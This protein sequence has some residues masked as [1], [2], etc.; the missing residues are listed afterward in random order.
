MR[1]LIES[2]YLP[3]PQ[4]LLKIS[5]AGGGTVFLAFLDFGSVLQSSPLILVCASWLLQ[6]KIMQLFSGILVAV[7]SVTVLVQECNIS[8]A[9]ETC[10]G[11]REQ[12]GENN[13]PLIRIWPNSVHL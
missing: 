2:P 4:S 12:K 5:I 3:L 7:C 11:Y 9:L 1:I 10:D 13:V 6:L 8:H